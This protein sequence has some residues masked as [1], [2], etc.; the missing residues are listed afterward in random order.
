LVAEIIFAQL[1]IAE[2]TFA[3]TSNCS[4]KLAEI[5]LLK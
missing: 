4:N 1:K 5:N 2:T 3:E